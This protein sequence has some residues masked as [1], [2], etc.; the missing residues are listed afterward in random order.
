MSA[1]SARASRAQRARC[2]RAQR[3]LARRA[4]SVPACVYVNTYVYRKRYAQIYRIK[5]IKGNLPQSDQTEEGCSLLFE[6][7]SNACSITLLQCDPLQ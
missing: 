1:C 4:Q 3:A 5:T 6:M 7:L 2:A